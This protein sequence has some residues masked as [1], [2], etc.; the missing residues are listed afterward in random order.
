MT[1]HDELRL[2]LGSYLTGALS[3]AARIEVGDHLKHCETCRAELVEL[4]ALPGLLGRLGPRP[5][6]SQPFGSSPFG[7][8]SSAASGS[9]AV[10]GGPPEGLLAEL[11]ARAR[12]IEDKSRWRLRRVRAATIAVAAAAVVTVAI[13]VAPRLASSPGT[14]YHLHAEIASARLAGQVTLVPKPWGT[15]LALS[16]QG[17]PAGASCEAVVSGIHGQ[18]VAIGN[19]SATPNHVARVDLASAMS[20]AQL[21]SLTIETAVGKPLLGLTLPRSR[22]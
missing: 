18:R 13:V 19:W 8:G 11:L 4:A 3:P 21:A 6:G 10:P 12:R 2:S 15:E 22:T 7:A 20:P 1:H 9:G 17:L 16:L 5:L 14:S